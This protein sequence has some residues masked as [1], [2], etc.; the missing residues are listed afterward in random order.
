MYNTNIV[1]IWQNYKVIIINNFMDSRNN[2]KIYIVQVPIFSR[3]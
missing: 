3:K 2:N 1:I